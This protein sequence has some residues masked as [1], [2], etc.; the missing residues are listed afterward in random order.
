MGFGISRKLNNSNRA[1]KQSAGKNAVSTGLLSLLGSKNKQNDIKN[2][3]NVNNCDDDDLT[4]EGRIYAEIKRR[5][6]NNPPK[7]YVRMDGSVPVP[8][9]DYISSHGHLLTSNLS[10]SQRSLYQNMAHSSPRS[11]HP[12]SRSTSSPSSTIRTKGPTPSVTQRQLPLKRVESLIG[13]RQNS[14]LSYKNPIVPQRKVISSSR[15]V[16]NSSSNLIS[17]TGGNLLIDKDILAKN[18]QHL[19]KNKR[20]ADGDMKRNVNSNASSKS[21]VSLDFEIDMLLNQKST[22]EDDV[23]ADK[24]KEAQEKMKKM[25]YRE[26]KQRKENEQVSIIIKAYHCLTCKRTSE[27]P[28]QLCNT[29]KHNV[30]VISIQKR[31]FECGKCGTRENSIG[32]RLPQK[33]CRCGA[34]MWKQTGKWG[35]GKVGKFANLTDDL[36]IGATDWTSLEDKSRIT[37]MRG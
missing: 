8:E 4:P 25:A 27:M 21:D 15:I 28:I 14:V 34:Y 17:V 29:Q 3:G 7:A 6:M 37:K 36:I 10:S 16:A 18:T 22:H 35:S 33:K 23:E 2:H 5:K 20:K 30:N 24:M 32:K 31:F 19:K 9:P 13:S 11:L 1:E 26:E 12:S